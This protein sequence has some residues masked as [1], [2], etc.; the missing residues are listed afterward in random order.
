L[1]NAV[2]CVG[3]RQGWHVVG[4]GVG[5]GT[6]VRRYGGSPVRQG[7]DTLQRRVGGAPIRRRSK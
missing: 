1:R 2:R 6:L 5:V 4:N 7:A 3:F